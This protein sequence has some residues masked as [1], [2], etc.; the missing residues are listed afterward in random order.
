[1]AEGVCVDRSIFGC[2]RQLC[3][4]DGPIFELVNSFVSIRLNRNFSYGLSFT[5]MMSRFR[6]F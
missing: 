6:N 1:M 5:G 3:G 4:V 2:V